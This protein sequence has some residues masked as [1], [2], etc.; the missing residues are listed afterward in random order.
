MEVPYC[1]QGG[2]TYASTND[3]KIFERLVELKGEKAHAA[4]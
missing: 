3:L 2:P 1:L 4:I